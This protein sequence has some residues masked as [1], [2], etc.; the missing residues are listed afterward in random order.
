MYYTT[1]FMNLNISLLIV[2]LVNSWASSW[3]MN[4]INNRDLQL[5]DAILLSDMHIVKQAIAQG[6]AINEKIDVVGQTFLDLAISKASG[7]IF[8][9][10]YQKSSARH[11]A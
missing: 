8:Y 3:A 4:N 2:F 11:L 1:I 6:V 5:R 7:A 9:K 10:N